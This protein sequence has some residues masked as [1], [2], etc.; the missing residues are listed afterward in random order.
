MAQA[1]QTASA[2]AALD[3]IPF[4]TLRNSASVCSITLHAA[5]AQWLGAYSRKT[6]RSDYRPSQVPLVLRP[7][8]L[9]VVDPHASPSLHNAIGL[10]YLLYIVRLSCRIAFF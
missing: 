2:P 8:M 4:A 10:R 9:R 6:P 7:V 3:A 1:R 5:E